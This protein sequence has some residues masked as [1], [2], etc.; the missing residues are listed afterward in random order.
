MTVQ[1]IITKPRYGTFSP[2]QTYALSVHSGLIKCVKNPLLSD[3][4]QQSRG[5]KLPFF[6]ILDTPILSPSFLFLR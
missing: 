5:L 3:Q 1:S 6:I 4:N 2:H